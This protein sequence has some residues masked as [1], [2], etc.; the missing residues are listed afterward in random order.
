MARPT[1]WRRTVYAA[2]SA[3]NGWRLSLIEVAPGET[4]TRLLSRFYL[5]SQGIPG[6]SAAVGWTA[7]IYARDPGDPSPSPD[8][9]DP[10]SYPWLWHGFTRPRSLYP[11]PQAQAMDALVTELS[12][13][14]EG[15]LD[16]HGQRLAATATGLQIEFVASP[17]FG[18][19][20]SETFLMIDMGAL[21]LQA[22]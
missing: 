6:L 11:D 14:Y 17:A 2:T 1:T 9:L 13:P 20:G 7:G 15:H 10:G 22:V 8:P 12:E 21:I 18:F 4:V 19:A 3:Q 16:L 5:I